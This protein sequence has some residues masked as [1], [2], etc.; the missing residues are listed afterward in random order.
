[1][2]RNE[3]KKIKDIP[4]MKGGAG[5]F[6]PNPQSEDEWREDGGSLKNIQGHVVTA[7]PYFLS[8]E[9]MLPKVGQK[10]HLMPLRM[11]V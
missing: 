10:A 11:F 6:N 4:N 5:K 2:Y 7:A 1:M 3:Y 9:N 8:E